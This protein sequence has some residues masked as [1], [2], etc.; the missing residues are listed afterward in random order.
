M[1]L[2][3]NDVLWKMSSVML[4]FK[5]NYLF[6]RV[7]PDSP[8]RTQNLPKA[9]IGQIDEYVSRPTARAKLETNGKLF[10]RTDFECKA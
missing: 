2:V 6:L 8:S 3:V 9:L 4:S 7:E 1:Q 10:E 5:K